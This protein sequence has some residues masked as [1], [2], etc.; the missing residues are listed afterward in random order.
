MATPMRTLFVNHGGGPCFFMPDGAMGP[1]GTWNSMA[2]HLKA[3][4]PS[5]VPKKPSAILLISAHWETNVP[6]VLS[7]ANPPLLYDYYGFP[8]ET[9]ELK[10]PAPGDPALASRVRELLEAGGFSTAE[11]STRGWDHG[12]FIP[13][14]LSFPDADVPTVQLSLIAGLDPEK[15][16]AMGRALAPLRKENVLIVGSGQSFHNMSGFFGG[17]FEEPSREFDV[18]LNETCAGVE[19]KAR[20]ERLRNWTAAP[21]ARAIHPRE[22]HL[23]PLFVTVG[24]AEDDPGEQI[25]SDVVLNLAMSGYAFG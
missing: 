21:S 10:W 5:V 17:G 2:S 3:L 9:Y 24:A 1:P 4:V 6:T 14:K 8:P 20:S 15:H 23:A 13:M 22:E 25:F 11:D 7:S 16:L 18:W 12:V 19:P